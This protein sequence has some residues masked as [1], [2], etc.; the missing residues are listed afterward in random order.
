MKVEIEIPKEFEEH[1]NY[2]R[3]EDSLK[4]VATDILDPH[5]ILSGNFELETIEMLQKAFLYAVVKE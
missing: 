1:F 4:R 5:C 2:D 3:F